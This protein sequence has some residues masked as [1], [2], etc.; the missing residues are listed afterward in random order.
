MSSFGVCENQMECCSER[1]CVKEILWLLLTADIYSV[2]Q[3]QTAA[4]CVYAD[5]VVYMMS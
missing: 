5:T 3:V 1:I 4:E 2:L